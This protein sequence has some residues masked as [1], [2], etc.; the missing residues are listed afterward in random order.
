MTGTLFNKTDLSFNV[1]DQTCFLRNNQSVLQRKTMN[2]FFCIKLLFEQDGLG[3]T[4]IEYLLWNPTKIIFHF[5]VLKD[6]M[7]VERKITALE[8]QFKRKK[9]FFFQYRIAFR[10]KKNE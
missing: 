9:R 3:F 4:N 1:F 2:L 8:N 10:S 7:F 5:F 6:Q